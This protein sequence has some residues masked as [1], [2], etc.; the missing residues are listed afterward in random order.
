[1]LKAVED[2]GWSIC[3]AA[4]WPRIV[5]AEDVLAERRV[6]V[7]PNQAIEIAKMCERRRTMDGTYLNGTCPGCPMKMRLNLECLN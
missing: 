3:L 2:H 4:D 5:E 1:M 7:P 6:S